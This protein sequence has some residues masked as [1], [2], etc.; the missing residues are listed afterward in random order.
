MQSV[1]RRKRNYILIGASG[2]P[3]NKAAKQAI[4]FNR[5]LRFKSVYERA[6][7]NVSYAGL[8]FGGETIQEKAEHRKRMSES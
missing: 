2:D 8:K 4:S 3:V 5:E 6:N 7:Q 1:G